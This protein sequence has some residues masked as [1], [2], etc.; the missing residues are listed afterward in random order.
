M[1]NNQC[2][3]GGSISKLG[4]LFQLDL[5]PMHW[6]RHTLALC[7]DAKCGPLMTGQL[8][9]LTLARARFEISNIFFLI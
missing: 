4:I 8:S 7:R 3:H 5:D 2:E 6:P 1:Q 9:G